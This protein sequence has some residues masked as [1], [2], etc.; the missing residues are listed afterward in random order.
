MVQTLT[1]DDEVVVVTQTDQNAPSKSAPSVPLRFLLRQLPQGKT[2]KL[3]SSSPHDIV[4][5]KRL[6]DESLK[7]R[8]T[9]LS[10][11]PGGLLSSYEA[12]VDAENKEDQQSVAGPRCTERQLDND[13]IT[14]ENKIVGNTADPDAPQPAGTAARVTVVGPDSN[15]VAPQS[16]ETQEQPETEAPVLFVGLE[17][18]EV[19]PQ[20]AQTQEEVPVVDHGFN[21][22]SVAETG[23]ED[24]TSF[25]AIFQHAKTHHLLRFGQT[26]TNTFRL[27]SG[28]RLNIGTGM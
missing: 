1:N 5:A 14:P 2:T 3:C 23:T 8:N 24:M 9:S 4:A 19:V 12:M 20:P 26:L 7:L 6:A 28:R 22:L 27:C 18:N 10:S 25:V 21:A 16:T 13:N 15:A 11:R 17:S